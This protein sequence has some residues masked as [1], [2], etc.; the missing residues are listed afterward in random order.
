MC[1]SPQ[2]P[3]CNFGSNKW[4]FNRATLELWHLK[5][6]SQS[7]TLLFN[8][9]MTVLIK[10]HNFRSNHFMNDIFHT[11]YSVKKIFSCRKVP[12]VTVLSSWRPLAPPWPLPWWNSQYG[13]YTHGQ[14][15]HGLSLSD[16]VY[17]LNFTVPELVFKNR[18]DCATCRIIPG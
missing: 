17:Y 4:N 11:R 13:N 2:I 5:Q 1:K 8:L 14:I 9:T 15:L 10:Q 18:M 12:E 7:K 16:Y 3:A 6:R